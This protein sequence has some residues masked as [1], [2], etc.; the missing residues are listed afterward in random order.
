MKKNYHLCYTSHREVMYRCEEDMNVAINCMCSALC[1]TDSACY[2]YSFMSDHHHGGYRTDCPGELIRIKRDSYT[3]YFNNKYLRKGKLGEEGFYLQE[4][5]GARHFVAAIAYIVK[6]PSHHGVTSIPFEYPFSSANA[7]FRKEL[8]KMRTEKPLSY[9]QIRRSLPRRALFEASWKMGT[10]D[11]F[12]PETV[13]DVTAVE[14]NF[15]TV[16]AFNYYMGRKSG[17]DWRAEQERDG[18][19]IPPFTL[20]N[21]EKPLLSVSEL[22]IAELLRNEKSRFSTVPIADLDL[23]RIIDMEYVKRFRKR[24]VY[25]LTLQEKNQIANELI[26]RFRA[27]RAQLI[28][29]LVI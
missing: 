2:A 26:A 5:E 11:V 17:E 15:G 18:N 10:D 21:M 9:E 13:L 24:T 27:G 3:K 6:N 1:R 28:R 16:Q 14:T 12:W 7:Y 8:G 19:T 20:E 22:T 23:C 29:C 4:I 25:E